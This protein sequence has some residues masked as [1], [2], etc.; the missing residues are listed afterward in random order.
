MAENSGGSVDFG[1]H[2]R[3]P[4]YRDDVIGIADDPQK[5]VWG[6]LLVYVSLEAD[7]TDRD[8]FPDA[9]NG[10]PITYRP[11]PR[12]QANNNSQSGRADD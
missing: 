8:R 5:N 2:F 1:G 7:L 12:P 11:I 6:T 3:S 4:S 9:W 10:Q